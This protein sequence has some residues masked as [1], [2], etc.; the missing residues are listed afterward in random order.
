MCILLCGSWFT[1]SKQLGKIAGLIEIAILATLKL[2][3]STQA[4]FF[5]IIDYVH[6]YNYLTSQT[7]S[8]KLMLF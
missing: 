1:N 2:A 7:L 8:V 3:T 6:N 4:G 5:L